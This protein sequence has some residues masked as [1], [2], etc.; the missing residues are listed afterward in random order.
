MGKLINRIPG[1]R[2]QAISK[3][4]LVNLISKDTHL[5]FSISCMTKRIFPNNFNICNL[6]CIYLKLISG[7]NGLDMQEAIIMHQPIYI[8]Q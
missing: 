2:Q 5:V 6:N 8:Y 1:S 7:I 4:F 3:P